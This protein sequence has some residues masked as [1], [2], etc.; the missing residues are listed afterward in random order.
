MSIKTIKHNN[1]TWNHI[2]RVDEEALNFLKTNFKFHPLDIKDVQGEAEESKI[3]IYK[4]YLFLILQF[5]IL[6]RSVGR[7]E[8]M[9][10]DVFM[11]D[12][13]L[14]TIQ[15]NRFKP[16]RDLY[17]KLQNSMKYRKSCFGESSGYLLYRILDVLYKDSSLI[18]KYIAQRLRKLEDEVYSGEIGEETARRIAYLRRKILGMKRI[19]DPEVE[20][21]GSLSR[22]KTKFISEDLNVYFDDLDDYVDKVTNFLDNKKY[23]MKDLLEVHDSLMTHKTNKVIKILTIFSVG[24]LPLTLL[25]GIYGMNINLPF[26]RQPM[27]IWGFFVGLLILIF[28]AVLFMKKRRLL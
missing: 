21:M 22:L 26:S 7:I 9:E 2:D 25:S 5:P 18:T 13:Y 15:K 16:M 8:F 17:Y 6:R 10:L 28:L 14:V 12:N 23:V 27:I 20:V 19:F 24:M 11:G 4:T 3:D 1:I